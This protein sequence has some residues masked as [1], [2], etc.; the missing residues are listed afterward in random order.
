MDQ[1]V[2]E[3]DKGLEVV[4]HTAR[5]EV[6][7]AADEVYFVQSDDTDYPVDPLDD[8]HGDNRYTAEGKD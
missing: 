6:D 3:T 4:E 8:Y 1:H 7:V 2:K 5:P